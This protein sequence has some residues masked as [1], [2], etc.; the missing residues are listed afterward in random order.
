[1]NFPTHNV[2]LAASAAQAKSQTHLLLP[3]LGG[4]SFVM[5]TETKPI[6]P[7]NKGQQAAADG[8]FAFL[9]TEEK[10]LILSG[11]GGYGKTY[12][13]GHLI[14]EIMPKYF[15][16][17]DLMGIKP[18]FDSVHM[19][20]TTNKAAEVLGEA[21]GRPASTIHSFLGLRVQEDYKTGRTNL[22]KIKD[23]WTVHQREIIFIDECSMIDKDLRRIILEGTLKSKIV[24]VGDHYQ[25]P[26][27]F[28]DL[29]P[30]YKD[31]LPF[32]E[33][34]QPM[35]TDV[36]EIQAVCD[37]LRETVRTGIFQPI[38]ATPG[39]VDWLDTDE[40]MA[41][42]DQ[43]FVQEE[44]NG[45]VLAYSNNQ[46][47]ALNQHIRAQRGLP[48]D[49]QVGDK[50]ISNSA[51]QLSTG[52]VSVEEPITIIAISKDVE[53]MKVGGAEF[54]VRYMDF[55]TPFNTF[56]QVPVPVDR[57]HFTSLMKYF[58]SQK[59]WMD[60]YELKNKYPDLRPRDACTVHKAQGSTYDIVFIDLDNLSTC[61]QPKLVARLLYVAFSRP[62]SRI[63]MYGQLAQ[64]YG[65][66]YE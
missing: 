34:T 48:E 54:D 5:T 51:L 3:L 25:L 53:T 17:C 30:I 4:A 58:A 47:N 13:L 33:L 37:Q 41:L 7:L 27:V 65:G 8:F 16:S 42:V 36:P 52:N 31:K 22:I 9:F 18:E 26:P 43:K 45:R 2:V 63:V 10:E 66:V 50:L 20:A 12:L 60:Y 64:R 39:V 59:S 38:K 32:F 62:R 46:V 23:K 29:S 14:D 55:E 61:T 15:K 56:T 24:Y 35:R 6:K 57:T 28:E 1:M 21:T 40:V 44:V 11:P 49:F 19:T